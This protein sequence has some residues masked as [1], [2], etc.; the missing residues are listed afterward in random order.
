MSKEPKILKLR[1]YNCQVNEANIPEKLLLRSDLTKERA[2]IREI[3]PG[4]KKGKN[5]VKYRCN[6][7]LN[8]CRKLFDSI[9]S[10]TTRNKIE[11]L[12]KAE[13]GPQ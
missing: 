11:M 10:D 12:F 7:G 3:T 5:I 13:Y 6:L 9:N 2:I 8:D 1:C 4:D